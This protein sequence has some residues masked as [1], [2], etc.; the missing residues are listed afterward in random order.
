V[1]EANLALPDY[2]QVH[3]WTRLQ[4]PFTAQ[5]GMATANGRPRRDAI[6]A[7]YQ[8]HFPAHTAEEL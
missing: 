4:Q 5:N 1:A 6:L 7:H 3:S 2:A 8:Q